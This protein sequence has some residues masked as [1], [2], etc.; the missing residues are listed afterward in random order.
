MHVSSLDLEEFRLYRQLL[1]PIPPAG[2]RIIGQN[3]SGKS[4][5]VEALALLATM[6]S[7]R[8]GSDRELI[9]W[10]SGSEL[11]FPPYARAICVVHS[12]DGQ[13]DIEVSLQV[14]AAGDGPL[15]KSVKINGRP[16]RVIDA[17]GQLK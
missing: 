12:V 16:T 8:T 4:T 15:H 10:N 1:L 2:L 11:G 3:A 5:L 9:R 7:P 6:R 13:T 17:V 14:D